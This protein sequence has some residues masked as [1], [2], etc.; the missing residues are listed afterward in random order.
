[1]YIDLASGEV[2]ALRL[3]GNL[4]AGER[5]LAWQ[6]PLHTGLAFGRVGQFVV[7]V[8]GVALVALCVTGF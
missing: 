2:A 6:F 3:A 7:A 5:F 8:T 1:M 4:S